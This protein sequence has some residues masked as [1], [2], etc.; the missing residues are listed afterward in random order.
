MNFLTDDYITLLLGIVSIF[1]L[2]TFFA[3][4]TRSANRV[5]NLRKIAND[6]GFE[7]IDTAPEKI[8]SPLQEHFPLFGKG[9][10]RFVRNILQGKTEL[11]TIKFFDFEYWMTVNAKGC[12]QQTILWVAY[13]ER[14]LPQFSLRSQ[15]WLDNIRRPDLAGRPFIILGNDS[16]QVQS[17]LDSKTIEYLDTFAGLNIEAAS[18]HLVIY[19]EDTKSS[20]SLLQADKETYQSLMSLGNVLTDLLSVKPS[21]IALS[22]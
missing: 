1:M 6:L 10:K 17:K 3:L 7:F 5:Q 13:E 12:T 4:L 22:R 11:G 14:P 9:K 16:E 18:N 21:N 2:T 20:E 19:L 15:N 8:I